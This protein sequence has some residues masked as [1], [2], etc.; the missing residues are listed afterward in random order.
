MQVEGHQEV[1]KAVIRLPGEKLH[2]QIGWEIRPDVQ[3]SAQQLRPV[4][5]LH[6]LDDLLT[7]IPGNDRTTAAAPALFTWPLPS[8]CLSAFRRESLTLRLILGN[9]AVESEAQMTPGREAMRDPFRPGDAW[10]GRRSAAIQ[11]SP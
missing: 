10:R 6:R 2:G 5:R 11:R 1:P 3:Q 8:E 9:M 4:H 7:S